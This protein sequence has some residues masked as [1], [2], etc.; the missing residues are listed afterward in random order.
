MD[1]TSAKILGMPTTTETHASASV[2]S[3]PTARQKILS[4]YG[5]AIPLADAD[6]Q[7][8]PCALK[9][10][11][12]MTKVAV[13]SANINAAQL[14]TSWTKKPAVALVSARV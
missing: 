10:S 3:E 8:K 12:G 4:K 7:L 13:V 6:V 14:A 9:N 1:A 11:I 2:H 5:G